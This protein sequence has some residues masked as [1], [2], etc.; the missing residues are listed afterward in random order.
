MPIRT[1]FKIIGAAAAAANLLW[2][3]NIAAKKEDKQTNNTNGNVILVKSIA[4][5]IFLI[6]SANPGAIKLTKI[7]IKISTIKTKKKRPKK[8]KLKIWLAK[9]FDLDLLFTN[10]EE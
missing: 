3:F 5:S 1:K 6:S 2:E 9:I 7:G 8:S 10:S 4:I